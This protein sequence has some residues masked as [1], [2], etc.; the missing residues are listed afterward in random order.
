M[1]RYQ[2][3][4][5]YNSL[6]WVF[7]SNSLISS[8]TIRICHLLKYPKT[9][10]CILENFPSTYSANV[11]HLTP[12]PKW[13]VKRPLTSTIASIYHKHLS[14]VCDKGRLTFCSSHTSTTQFIHGKMLITAFIRLFVELITP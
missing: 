3:N 5:T 2:R 11:C 12:H 1:Y 8:F 13:D 10:S 4:Y 6:K 14:R 7:Y 9:C